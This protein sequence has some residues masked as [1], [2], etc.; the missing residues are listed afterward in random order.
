MSRGCLLVRTGSRGLTR[1]RDRIGRVDARWP[2]RRVSVNRR[3]AA[4]VPRLFFPRFGLIRVCFFASASERWGRSRAC[5]RAFSSAVWAIRV[6]FFASASERW[7]S[8][9]CSCAFFFRGL[10]GLSLL[11]RLGFRKLGLLS[12]AF[13]ALRAC[14]F[15]SPHC[16]QEIPNKSKARKRPTARPA[17]MKNCRKNCRRMHSWPAP[18]PED[19]DIIED[20]QGQHVVEDL[21]AIRVGGAVHLAEDAALLRGEP[22]QDGLDLVSR[23]R[24]SAQR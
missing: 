21:V 15:A 18:R 12:R 7:A 14:F 22:P 16:H 5:S 9:V 10:G 8:R 23:A 13:W 19:R 11:F 17:L 20:D 6:C 24:P 1:G 2:A 3:V 4:S